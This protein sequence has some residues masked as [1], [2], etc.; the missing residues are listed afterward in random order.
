MG[1]TS[2]R[3]R[4]IGRPPIDVADGLIAATALVHDLTLWTRNTQ[5]FDGLGVRLFNPWE[6]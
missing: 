5:D 3:A 4:R 2:P 1:R 6:D